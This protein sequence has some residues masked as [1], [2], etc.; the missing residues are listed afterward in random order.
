MQ[1]RWDLNGLEHD[2]FGGC[3]AHKKLKTMIDACCFDLQLDVDS[4]Y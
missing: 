3:D 1:N 4:N 2:Y